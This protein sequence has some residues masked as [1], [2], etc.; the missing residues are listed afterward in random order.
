MYRITRLL[1]ASLVLA[2]LTTGCGLFDRPTPSPPT[3]IPAPPPAVLTQVAATLTAAAPTAPIVS[4]AIP[5]ATQVLPTEVAIITATPLT[6]QPTPSAAPTEV[7][8]PTVQLL[9][10]PPNSEVTAGQAVSVVALAVDDS[11]ISRVELFAD[12]AMYS[13]QSPPAGTSPTTFQAIFTWSSNAVGQHSLFVLAYDP[14]GNASAPAVAA[15][16]IVQNN[17]PPQV[18]ILAPPSPQNVNLGSQLQV[19]VV[20]NG[21][22]NIVQ[23]QM[24]VDNQPY[25][26]ANA[27]T[28][29]GINPFSATFIYAANVPGTHTITYRAVD[30]AGNIGVSGALTVN[31]SDNTPPSVNASYSRFNIRQNEQVVVT[32]VAADSAGLQRVELWADNA[33]YTLYNVPNPRAQTSIRLQQY[34]TSGAPGNHNLFVR[35]FDVNGQSSTTPATNIVVRQPD[36]PTWTPTPYIPPPTRY[37]TM[38]PTEPLP[39]PPGA[40]LLAPGLG[41]NAEIPNPLRVAAEFHSDAGLR[42]IEVWAQYERLM[43]QPIKVE[44]AN[45]QRDHRIE[46]DWV[47]QAPGVVGIFA[48][49][50]DIFGQRGESLHIGCT[51]YEPRPPTIPPPPTFEPPPTI[52]P[53]PTFEPPT[54]EP[55]RP[56]I[57]G[58]WRGEVDNGFFIIELESRIG[59]SEFSCAW[60]GT[61][62]DHRGGELV[63]GGLNGQLNG[64]S[65]SL[66]VEGAQP[67]DVTWSFNGSVTAGGQEIVGEWTESRAGLGSL[68]RGSVA[69]RRQ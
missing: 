32:T 31:A 26:Q 62:E 52:P 56:S 19:R 30:T 64:D 40:N 44:D 25:T 59:C 22:L 17:T 41:C 54:R 34:W 2:A 63:R 15:V 66:N 60:G 45:G 21:N 29:A 23:M 11:G 36:Q 50:N 33:L 69:F 42:T 57:A 68:Q 24:L 38:T 4:T 8:P 12:N 47:P 7:N 58:R 28:P 51:V 3:Q 55:E 37:P 61:F 46:F 20:A 5:P 48:T 53:P 10:P 1:F 67:G 27:P 35:V 9:S 13:V 18:A 43:A 14:Y 49:A 39:P 65:L 16:T 6:A